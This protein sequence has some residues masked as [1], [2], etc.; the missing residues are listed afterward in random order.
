MSHELRTQLTAIKGSAATV[1]S[2]SSAMNDSEMRQSFQ[3]V[4][5]QAPTPCAA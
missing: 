3:I 4:D 1:L 2:A 5:E